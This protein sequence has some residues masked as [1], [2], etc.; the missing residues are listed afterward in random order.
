MKKLLTLAILLVTMASVASAQS[1]S[2]SIFL[3]STPTHVPTDTVSGTTTKAQTA[4]ISVINSAVGIQVDLTTI[5]GTPGGVVRLYGS[6]NGTRF[7]RILPTDSLIVDANRRSKIFPIALPVYTHY[8]VEWVP[9]GTHS[10][11][12]NSVAVFRKQ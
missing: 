7:T 12:M 9:T 11:K 1:S 3:K 4:Q 5:S 8:R 2:G 10:T 6:L